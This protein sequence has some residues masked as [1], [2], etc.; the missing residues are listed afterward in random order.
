MNLNSEL[1]GTTK[2][3][4][5]IYLVAKL[6]SENPSSIGG[7]FK[8]KNPSLRWHYKNKP[9]INGGKMKRKRGNEI[10][11]ELRFRKA[12]FIRPEIWIFEWWNFPR[13]PNLERLIFVLDR[14]KK[15]KSPFYSKIHRLIDVASLSNKI[16]IS[17]VP[18]I[19]PYNLTRIENQIQFTSEI[20]QSSIGGKL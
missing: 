16:D 17:L 8:R 2:V 9:V 19:F 15:K 20:N 13:N 18:E 12:N 7:K 3:K 6:K 4:S 14:K 10:T 1:G 5:V 11:P